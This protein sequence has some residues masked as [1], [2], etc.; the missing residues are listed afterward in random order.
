[1]EM[2]EKRMVNIEDICIACAGR[3][4]R[5]ISRASTSLEVKD[6]SLRSE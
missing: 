2:K 6:S 1:M 3:V 4:Q 5:S